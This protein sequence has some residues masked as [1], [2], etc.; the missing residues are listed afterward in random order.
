LFCN[1]FFFIVCWKTNKKIDNLIEQTT[2]DISFLCITGGDGIYGGILG[3]TNDDNN[4]HEFKNSGVNNLTFDTIYSTPNL[5]HAVQLTE[6]ANTYNINPNEILTTFGIFSFEKQCVFKD[7]IWEDVTLEYRIPYENL[8]II[9]I[10]FDD[11]NHYDLIGNSYANLIYIDDG[12]SNANCDGRD[13]FDSSGHV[14]TIRSLWC[15]SFIFFLT[16]VFQIYLFSKRVDRWEALRCK[17]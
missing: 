9:P 3:L 8:A 11:T 1:F 4:E 13:S 14:S 2:T 16:S 17:S 10:D 6:D 12:F 5:I 7:G 15:G